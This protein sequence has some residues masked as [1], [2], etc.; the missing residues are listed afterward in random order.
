MPPLPGGGHDA[1]LQ[2]KITLGVNGAAFGSPQLFQC[3]VA[4]MQYQ[5]LRSVSDNHVFVICCDGGL[6][7]DTNRP[8]PRKLAN[9]DYPNSRIFR[10][11]LEP[12]CE[13]CQS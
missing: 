12:G 11:S 4:L 3:Y 9:E 10:V 6:H 7:E 13:W 8:A 1:D 2:A 5:T